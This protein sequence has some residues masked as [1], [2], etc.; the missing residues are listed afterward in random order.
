MGRAKKYNNR[1]LQQGVERYFRSI[2]RMAPVYEELPT[3]AYTRAGRPETQP[4]AACNDAGEPMRAPVYT[5]TPS[6]AG[7]CLALGISKTTL[8]AYG[9]DES[10]RGT[11]EGV[12]LRIEA[13][14]I[15]QLNGKNAAGARFA[16]ANNFGW[17]GWRE[18]QEVELGDATRECLAAN[19]S[20]EEKLQLIRQAEQAVR[21]DGR[22]SGDANAQGEPG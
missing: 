1:Q 10:M 16:L 2:C 13:Y 14:W 18:C 3:G 15:E 4:V 7:L 22:L 11:V 20:L 5:Q 19:M 9:R 17:C 6:F 12:R 21:E 8:E